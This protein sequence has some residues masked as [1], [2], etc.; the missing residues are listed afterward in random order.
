MEAR[1]IVGQ[2]GVAVPAVFGFIAV[3]N[4]AVVGRVRGGLQKIFEKIDGVVQHVIVRA[5]HVDIQLALQL[6]AEL[7]P[8]A[9][10]NCA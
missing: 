10:E 7:G 9:L 5:A 3:F 1:E 8:I 4:F 2:I 6:R